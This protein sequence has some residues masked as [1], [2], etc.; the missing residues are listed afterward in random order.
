[1]S[2]MRAYYRRLSGWQR[3]LRGLVHFSARFLAHFLAVVP[4]TQCPEW[5]VVEAGHDREVKGHWKI[6]ETPSVL[7]D[8][9]N[10]QSSRA[11]NRPQS[12]GDEPAHRW[13]EHPRRHGASLRG[14]SRFPASLGMGWCGHCPDHGTDTAAAR[15]QWPTDADIH[16]AFVVVR[17]R[18]RVA[19]DADRQLAAHDAVVRPGPTSS[20]DRY[21]APGRGRRWRHRHGRRQ[22]RHARPR[23]SRAG[24]L[25]LGGGT[26]P[27][28]PHAGLRAALAWT[29]G[30]SAAILALV[31][32]GDTMPAPVALQPPSWPPPG[33]PTAHPLAATRSAF[34]WE[35]EIGAGDH[36]IWCKADRNYAHLHL[37]QACGDN[38]LTAR[39]PIGQ[40]RR[41]SRRIASCGCTA[42]HRRR[43]DVAELRTPRD[44][45]ASWLLRSGVTV[46]VSREG[47]RLL[48]EQMGPAI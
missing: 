48:K 26:D 21:G 16:G 13:Y 5:V 36:I 23:P 10:A 40:L 22:P 14:H 45:G 8:R 12:R 29:G 1:M 47:K 37:R 4:A 19:G 24:S 39:L 38:A 11:I 6:R 31:A 30:C 41:D 18:H 42:H 43:G 46:P 32:I 35:A 34:V 9:R 20:V 27:D 7:P 17:H 25:H 3:R 2:R 33:R 15:R 44:R 28:G